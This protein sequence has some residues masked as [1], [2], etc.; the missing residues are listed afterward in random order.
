MM[1][2]PRDDERAIRVQ[3]MVDDW[4]KSGLLQPEPRERI[5]ADL[6]VDYRRTNKF[7]RITLFLFGFLIVHAIVGLIALMSDAREGFAY[8]LIVAAVGVFFL[9]QWLIARYRFYRFGIEEA[10]AVSAV[11][12]FGFGCAIVT[13]DFS[14]LRGFIGLAGA[15]FIVFGR[16]GYLYAGI[17]AVLFA[18]VLPLSF[19]IFNV[20]FQADTTRRLISIVTLMV[21][22]GIARERRQDHDWEFP[23]DLY[24][25][26]E[27]TAWAALYLMVNLRATTWLSYPDEAVPMFYWATYA[28]I[29]I[30]PAVGLLL[31]V[32]DRHR[33]MLDANILMALVT[34][35]T[36]KPYLSGVQKPWDPILFGVLLI[37]IALILKRW[38]SSGADGSRRGFIAERLL[39]SEAERLALAGGVAALRVGAP[40]PHTH[41][42][43]EM[44]GGGSSGGAGASGK[45]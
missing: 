9:A 19:S 41:P 25:A 30:L 28:G 42:A 10:A 22:F 23:G 21:I 29:W 37:A 36:N 7:L 33:W 34:L 17:A 40:E 20:A 14:A 3:R 35:M 8:M 39:A 26:L 27:T 44:G 6:A 5:Q 24:A 1:I 45:F 4:T 38:L 32:R 11:T 31:A 16:F 43:P 15:A 2:Y 18:G 12:L 13:N